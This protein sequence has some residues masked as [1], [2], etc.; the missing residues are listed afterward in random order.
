MNRKT[1]E[2]YRFKSEHP[3]SQ[4]FL[5]DDFEDSENREGNQENKG[6]LIE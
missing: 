1:K 5:D 3:S 6:G 2:K 4:T